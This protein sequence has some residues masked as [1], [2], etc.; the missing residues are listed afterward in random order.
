[1]HDHEG[2]TGREGADVCGRRWGQSAPEIGSAQLACKQAGLGIGVYLQGS[3][4]SVLQKDWSMRFHSVAG[5]TCVI[6]CAQ[7]GPN[8]YLF[9]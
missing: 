5:H 4:C 8:V 7:L 3:I 2:Q 9:P 1:M 6:V